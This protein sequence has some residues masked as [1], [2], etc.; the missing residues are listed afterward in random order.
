M[1]EYLSYLNMKEISKNLQTVLKNLNWKFMTLSEYRHAI[2]RGDL[3]KKEH[4]TDD[5]LFEMMYPDHPLAFSNKL[6]RIEAADTVMYTELKLPQAVFDV[7]HI[8]LFDC[9]P[10]V[11][12]SITR[13]LIRSGNETSI[14]FLERLIEE[15]DESQIVRN[16]ATIALGRIKDNLLVFEKDFMIYSGCGEGNVLNGEGKLLY[17]LGTLVYEG[18]FKNNLF[19][20]YGIL[21]NIDGTINKKGKFIEGKHLDDIIDERDRD[22]ILVAH[23]TFYK[24]IDHAQ[25]YSKLKT[26]FKESN[27]QYE[28]LILDD[29]TSERSWRQA[30]ELADDLIRYRA[31]AFII[32]SSI[33]LQVDDLSNSIHDRISNGSRAVFLIR[34]KDDSDLTLMNRFLDKYGM[35]CSKIRIHDPNDR[36][37]TIRRSKD[38]FR[39]PSLFAGVAEVYISSAKSLD[40]YGDAQQVLFVSHDHVFTDESDLPVHWIDPA[41]KCVG[42]AYHNANDGALICISGM[43]LHDE[44][45]ERNHQLIRNI[46]KFLSNSKIPPRFKIDRHVKS[47]E[48]NL[49][50]F[51]ILPLKKKREDWWETFVPPPVQEACKKKQTEE[52]NQIKEI[53]A[54]LT[55]FDMKKIL[56]RNWC[57]YKDFVSCLGLESKKLFLNRIDKFNK[58]RK[59]SAHPVKRHVTKHDY[60]PKDVEEIEELDKVM[61]KLVRAVFEDSV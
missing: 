29:Y 21:Y 58:P 23:L 33:C 52:K 49:A 2:T 54:Y 4:L 28:Y 34:P 13:T 37:L 10:G 22:R 14:P 8:H 9:S 51:T 48:R 27:V 31:D 50:D 55:I 38:N 57:I 18:H 61:K 26:I 24:E 44:L 43:F 40:C 45:S 53:E 42:A 59:F 3:Q 47:I 39:D 19:H 12:E 30:W 46:V 20:G 32:D 41:L 36:F 6:K 60:S 35:S 16:L 25:T 7:L 15:E 5:I 11:R 56:Q 17:E 1:I